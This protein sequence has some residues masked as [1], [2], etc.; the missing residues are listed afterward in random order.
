MSEPA[1][2]IDRLYELLPVVYRRRD[3]EQGQPL[4]NLLR[5]IAEQVNLIEDDIGRMYDDWFIETCRNWVVPYIGDLVG[6]EVLPIPGA[7]APRRDVA[8]TIRALRRRGTLALLELLANDSASFPAR[9][10]EFFALLGKTQSLNHLDEQ[11]GFVDL[12]DGEALDLIDSPFDSAGHTVDIRGVNAARNPGRHNIPNAAAY[13]WRLRAFPVT[14][15]PAYFTQRGSGYFFY[16]FS[17]LGNDAPIFAAAKR[18]SDPTAIA[19]EINLPVPIR[20]RALDLHRDDYYGPSFLLWLDGAETP[21]PAEN[22]IAADLSAWTYR[23]PVGKVAVDPQL[24][25]I[26]LAKQPE[27]IE[28]TYHYGFGGDVGAHESPRTLAQPRGAALYRVGPSEAHATIADAVRQWTKEAPQHAVIEIADSGVYTEAVDVTLREG[29]TLQIRGANRTRPVL[30]VLDYRPSHGE[31]LHVTMYPKSRFTLDGLVVAGRPLQ[32]EGA[33]EQ[34]VDARVVIRRST[35]VPGWT[36]HPNCEPGASDEASL[37]IENLSGK[38]TIEKSIV[39]TIAVMNETDEAEPIAIAVSDSIVDATSNEGDA[40]IGPGGSYAWATLTFARCTVFGKVLAHALA[41]AENTIFGAPATIVRRQ[42][43]CVRFCY[44]PPGSRT[45]RRYHCQPDLAEAAVRERLKKK[46]K[47]AIEAA[48]ERERRRVVP[49][50]G[51]TRFGASDYCQLGVCCAPEIARGADD[52][53][54]MGAFHDLFLPQ[55]LANLRARLDRSTPAAMETGVI[56]AD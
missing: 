25:R 33:G 18:E 41:L 5:A 6:Y 51:S 10:V 32:I 14:H 22:V 31:S 35:L 8:N 20:R 30:Q 1:E 50:F 7:V 29:T 45:P 46:P 16:T 15:A 43:G 12:R 53:S 49:R 55:R 19:A 52:E 13:V 3:L 11:G 27:S 38:V 17:Q 48:L 39:G 44:V 21:V 42:G 37:G 26:A 24:G 54:E 9:A 28:V 40:V 2:R 4:R 47:A 36:L 23:P 56:F 34:A